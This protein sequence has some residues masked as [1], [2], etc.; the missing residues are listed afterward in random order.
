MILVFIPLLY[1]A[2]G[3]AQMVVHL[4]SKHKTLSSNT[5]TG[6]KKKKGFAYSVMAQEK[7]VRGYEKHK[8]DV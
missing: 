7:H 2:R 3:L 8:L 4:P 5:S 6:K 1:V